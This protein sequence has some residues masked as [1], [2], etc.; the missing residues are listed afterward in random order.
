MTSPWLPFH[1]EHFRALLAGG[2][3]LGRIIAWTNRS[4]QD[5]RAKADELGLTLPGAVA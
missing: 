1:V 4:E 3:T 2:H 5:L